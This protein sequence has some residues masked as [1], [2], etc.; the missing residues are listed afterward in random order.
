MNRYFNKIEC[1]RSVVD[2]YE[3]AIIKIVCVV[4]SFGADVAD[5]AF[6]EG[7]AR[8]DTTKPLLT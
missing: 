5:I 8:R 6:V 1:K 4:N 3:L 2:V 7:L